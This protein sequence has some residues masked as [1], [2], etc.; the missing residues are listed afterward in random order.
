VSIAPFDVVVT[1]DGKTAFVSNR[2]GVDPA[3]TTKPLRHPEH[4]LSWTSAASPGAAR[5]ARSIWTR[6]ADRRGGDGLHPRPLLHESSG[7]L[8]VANANSDTVTVLDA[9]AFR[10]VETIVVRPDPSLEFGSA[11]N[12]LALAPDGRT[13]YVANGGNNAVAILGLAAKA[14][15]KSKL[16]GFLPTA[17]YPALARWRRVVHRQRQGLRRAARSRAGRVVRSTPTRGS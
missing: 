14:G 5:S 3:R 13:L 4:S 7:R 8:F 6:K 9:A 17:W 16:A 1:A 15:D 11:S 2:G 12:A 10:E